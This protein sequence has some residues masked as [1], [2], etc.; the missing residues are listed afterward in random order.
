MENTATESYNYYIPEKRVQVGFNH[1]LAK[2]VGLMV[3]YVKD[4]DYGTSH[5]CSLN[6]RGKDAAPCRGKLEQLLR[7]R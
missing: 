3:T 2:G 1:D 7:N 5:N 6:N 4:D